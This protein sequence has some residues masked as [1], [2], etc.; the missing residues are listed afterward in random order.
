M[1]L[2]SDDE[3]EKED[4]VVVIDI[5][6]ADASRRA[7]FVHAEGRQ[8]CY[9]VRKSRRAGATVVESEGL[10]GLFARFWSVR[11]FS[12]LDNHSRYC[13]HCEERR[14]RR[15][16]W[17]ECVRVA[18]N[19]RR[20][21]PSVLSFCCWINCPHLHNTLLAGT[22]T[23]GTERACSQSGETCGG[24]CERDHAEEGCQLNA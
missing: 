24:R 23:A 12:S 11:K 7:M 19:S 14:S 21:D 6:V 20:C 8:R 10:I 22:G 16:R 2:E 17:T 13:D 3:V 18:T 4:V 1:S 15:R 5:G 9:R